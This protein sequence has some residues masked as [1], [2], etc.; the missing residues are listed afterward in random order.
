MSQTVRTSSIFNRSI[1]CTSL[2]KPSMVRRSPRSRLWAILDMTRWFS[3]S[4]AAVSVSASFKPRRGQSLRAICAPSDGMILLAALGDVMQQQGDVKRAAMRDG[5][6]DFAGQRQFGRTLAQL[7]RGQFAQRAQ[8]MLVHRIVV[9]HVELHH[10]D[11]AA[12]IGNE[13]AEH[14]GFVHQPQG[15]FARLRRGEDFDEQPVGFRVGAQFRVYARQGLGHQPQGVGMDRQFIAR[16]HPEQ[17][18]Q[19][20]RLLVEH[21]GRGHGDAVGFQREGAEIPRLGPPPQFSDKTV[22]H[23]ARLGLALLQR[24]AD[25]IGQ[26]ADILGDGEIMLH[27]AFDRRQ[28]VARRIAELFRN[29]RAANRNSAA[30]RRGR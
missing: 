6:H 22:E 14:A 11:D 1:V 16:R 13:A 3:T 21:V 24:G 27:E 4:Q 19:I 29:R 23:G 15:A 18:D 28:A 26:I 9:V 2:A 5:R 10:R 25:D 12:E 20:D 7:H 8:Q 30:P 17:P